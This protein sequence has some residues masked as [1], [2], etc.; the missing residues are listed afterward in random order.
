MADIGKPLYRLLEKDTGCKWTKNEQ[1][2]F[3]NL[4][5]VL[6]TAP[7]FIF[8]QNLPLKLDFDA[9]KYGLGGVLFHVYPEKK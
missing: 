8:D 3:E 6:L 9:S 7:V 4:K 1:L 2:S 5:Q